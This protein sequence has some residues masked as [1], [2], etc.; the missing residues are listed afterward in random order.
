MIK[1]RG[2]SWWVVV[3][4]GRDP[5]T[6]RKRQKT[7][8]ADTKAEVR[9][10]EARLISEA[11]AGKHKGAATKTVADLLTAWL[12]W[13]QGVRPISPNGAL[14]DEKASLSRSPRSRWSPT[15]RR[16]TGCAWRTWP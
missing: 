12:E 6:G 8:T 2:N 7:G 4:A 1:K 3:C 10:L 16:R 14:L 13:R 15:A 11:G 5:L 9:Q